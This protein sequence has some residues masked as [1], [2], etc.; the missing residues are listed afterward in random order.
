V[1]VAPWEAHAL[2]LGCVAIAVVLAASATRARGRRRGLFAAAVI[3]VATWLH[4]HAAEVI[5]VSDGDR[6]PVA[7]RHVHLGS[8]APCGRDATWLVN[9]SSRTLVLERAGR[10]EPLAPATATCLAPVDYLKI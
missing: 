4:F 8:S 9:A 7:K 5:V 6:D 3:G 1:L 10:D 2:V